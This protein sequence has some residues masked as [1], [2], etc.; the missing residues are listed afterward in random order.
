MTSMVI[1]RCIEWEKVF[2]M[3]LTWILIYSEFRGK[4]QET[5]HLL[6]RDREF[7][8]ITTQLSHTAYRALQ[9]SNRL[10]NTNFKFKP[11]EF[12]TLANSSDTEVR[13]GLCPGLNKCCNAMKP[14]ANNCTVLYL[15]A[16]LVEGIE[17]PFQSQAV[18]DGQ[19]SEKR[20]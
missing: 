15:T 20:Q 7:Q 3:S 12:R 11:R 8:Q 2:S 10:V 19:K 13:K 14:P 1:L 6:S 5:P 18:S 4:S 17:T 16:E 9:R